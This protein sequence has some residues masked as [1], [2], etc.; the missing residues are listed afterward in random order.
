MQE[1]RHFL[2]K[3]LLKKLMLAHT[4]AESVGSSSSAV[5]SSAEVVAVVETRDGWSSIVCF[6]SASFGGVRV[7]RSGS[8]GLLFPLFCCR[9]LAQMSME[10]TSF[11]EFFR[12]VPL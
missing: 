9:L 5:S 10:F 8:N 1:C 11:G 4:T 12:F 2:T 7:A 6:H 3:S